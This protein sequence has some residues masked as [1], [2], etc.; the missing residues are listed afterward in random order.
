[1]GTCKAIVQEGPRKGEGC[2]FPGGENLYCDRHQRNYQ[3][4]TKKS[5]TKKDFIPFEKLLNLDSILP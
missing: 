5:P 1:M 2:K 4:D 3:H